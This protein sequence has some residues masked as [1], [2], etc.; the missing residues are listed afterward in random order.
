MMAFRRK[1]SYQLKTRSKAMTTQQPQ[2]YTQSRMIYYLIE[3]VEE[4][5]TEE[6][7]VETKTKITTTMMA[8]E[9]A[10]E[11]A[12]E[13]AI[14]RMNRIHKVI[15]SSLSREEMKDSITKLLR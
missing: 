11:E 13:E 2:L 7:V 6:E 8:E 14:I 5:I 9:A 12:E 3:V 15:R 10:E 1:I 4:E